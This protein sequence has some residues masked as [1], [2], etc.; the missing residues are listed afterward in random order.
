VDVLGVLLLIW[1]S[2]DTF[3]GLIPGYLWASLFLFIGL[4]YQLISW[5]NYL[6]HRLD[7]LESSIE[8]AQRPRGGMWLD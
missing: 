5:G 2:L 1:N 6:A 4:S 3:L 7:H 8:A